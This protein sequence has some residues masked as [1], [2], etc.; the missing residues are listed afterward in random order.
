MKKFTFASLIIFLTL[1]ALFAQKYDNPIAQKITHPELQII[2]I[3]ISDSNTII[4]LKVTNKRNQGGWFCADEQIYL[5]NSKGTEMYEL[6]RS[7]NIPTCPEQFK[8]SYVGQELN[9]TLYFPPISKD[10]RF[11][12]LIEDCSNACFSFHGIILDN[13]HNEKIRAFEQGFELY[14]N[15]QHKEAIPLFEKVLTGDI[16]IDSHIYGL[17]YYYLIIIYK[18]LGDADKM[19]E[20]YEKLFNSNLDDK[21]TFI[22]ELEKEEIKKKSS[23]GN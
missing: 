21:A 9:F 22:K 19:N 1:S 23:S 14:Q 7:E 20:W 18:E 8:F 10:I 17:S 13:E 6:I 15:L 11:L 4:T 2:S 16:S 5:K 3:E 12:D